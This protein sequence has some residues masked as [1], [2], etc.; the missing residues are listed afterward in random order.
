MISI[1]HDA[2]AVFTAVL[3]QCVGMDPVTLVD[4]GTGAGSPGAPESGASHEKAPVS[5]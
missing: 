2:G 5:P 3:P 1:G 4:P